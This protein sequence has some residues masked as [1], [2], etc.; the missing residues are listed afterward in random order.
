M[1]M[2]NESS[3]RS[4]D[5]LVGP[6]ARVMEF[7]KLDLIPRP[8]VTAVKTEDES[9]YRKYKHALKAKSSSGSVVTSV[10]YNPV[11]KRQVAVTHGTRVELLTLPVGRKPAANEYKADMLW[12]KH[13]DFTTCV[14]FRNDGK[15]I[16]AGD[17]SGKI[18]VYDLTA[19]RNILRRF[20]GGHEGAVNS[21]CFAAHDRTL[22]YSAGKDGKVIQWSLSSDTRTAS[23]GGTLIG[24]HDDAVQVVLATTAGSIITAGY[25]GYVHVWNAAESE[26]DVSM[27]ADDAE[28]AP[29]PVTSYSHGSPI[30]AACLSRN[31]TL[32]Y[33]AGGGFVS[34]I[35]LIAG[36]IEQKSPLRHSK[37]VTGMCVNG[38]GDVVT[39]SLD[40]MVKVWDTAGLKEEEEGESKG[41]KLLHTYKY[42]GHGVTDVA[43]SGGQGLSMVVCLDDGSLV[44]R[45]RRP[46]DGEADDTEGSTLLRP[47]RAVGSVGVSP[48]G[49][50]QYFTQ[51]AKVKHS[52]LE[53]LLR[54][55]EYPKL[56]DAVVE[57]STP[58]VIGASVLDELRQRGALTGATR[59]RTD[60]E[61]AKIVDY[62][63]KL[64]SSWDGPRLV[65]LVASVLDA[66]TATNQK[67]FANPTEKLVKALNH[68]S[69]TINSELT[70]EQKIL[71]CVGLLEMFDQQLL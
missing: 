51:T 27:E 24:K 17:G 68:L 22:V 49:G 20:R 45:R 71:P 44:S 32:L 39:G 40:G 46:Q 29:Q 15:L 42:Q 36:K 50:V 33:V 11:N 70:N 52:H 31:Q 38:R 9:F 35:D 69:A 12:S 55:F 7:T 53:V 25:D 61:C 2:P 18:N 65:S 34:I 43:W 60:E 3:P 63:G 5:G 6:F 8:A 30:D 13:K 48:S 62:L 56:L 16:A 64:M 41:W 58:K 57:G 47:M 4:P 28:G 67:V 37:A 10:A 19:T 59:N 26:E 23:E 21:V 14:A 54:R 66:L 1:S